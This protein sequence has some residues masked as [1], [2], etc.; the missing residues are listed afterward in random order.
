MF[1]I[2]PTYVQDLALGLELYEVHTDPHLEPVNFPQDDIPSL[3]SIN[4]TA[5]LGAIY[6]LSEGSIPVSVPPVK[7]STCSL[8][9]FFFFPDSSV[10]PM[11]ILP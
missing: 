9:F 7:L 10:Q 8:L 3:Q 4:C 2:T 6:K 5:Q 11:F 1:G